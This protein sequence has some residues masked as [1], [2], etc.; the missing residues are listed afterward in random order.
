M[1]GCTSKTTNEQATPVPADSDSVTKPASTTVA[2]LEQEVLRTQLYDYTNDKPVYEGTKPAVIDVY[3]T[4]C[5]PC[6]KMS[7]ILE[8]LAIEM[9]DSIDFYK[10]DAEEETDAAEMLHIEGYPTF[11]LLSPGK[12]AYVHLGSL[13]KE[14]FRQL[15]RTRLL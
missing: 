8:E 7:P 9:G 12:P 2:Y 6:K 1:I 14:A 10:F 13:S 11:L 15:L 3:T 4:W 5:P